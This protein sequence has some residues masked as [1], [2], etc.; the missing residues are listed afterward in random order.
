MIIEFLSKR[1]FSSF[2]DI[3]DD[4]HKQALE[5]LKKK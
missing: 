3:P 2:G 5:Y 1:Y 4:T